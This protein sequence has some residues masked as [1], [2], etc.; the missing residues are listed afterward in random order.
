[1]SS[2]DVPVDAP[3]GDRAHRLVPGFDR[4][5]DVATGLVM[6]EAG[7]DPRVL[8]L[9]AGPGSLP[10]RL[11]RARPAATFTLLDPD[12]DRLGEL[13]ARLDA[14]GVAHTEV[15]GELTE[16]PAQEFDAAVSGLVLHRLLDDDKRLVFRRLREVMR[17]DGLFV[18]AE[19]VAGPSLALDD[20]Y[21]RTW[22]EQARDA[23]ADDA[24]IDESVQ[25]MV[26]DHPA[27]LPDLLAWLVEVGFRDVD[28][29]YKDYRFAVLGGWSGMAAAS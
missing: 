4:L 21:H 5:F 1:M 26:Y 9:G 18:S 11:A 13:A 7:E 25:Q 22:M 12:P 3:R 27:T 14:V 2:T 15:T 16:P 24:E 19:Q 29:F 10:E 6:A 28:C 8:V 23:G 17:R 20:L